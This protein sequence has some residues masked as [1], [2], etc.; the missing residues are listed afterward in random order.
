[1]A[2]DGVAGVRREKQAGKYSCGCCCSVLVFLWEGLMKGNMEVIGIA[3][4][5]GIHGR[6]FATASLFAVDGLWFMGRK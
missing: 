1:M 6:E 3:R 4:N 5:R 2:V